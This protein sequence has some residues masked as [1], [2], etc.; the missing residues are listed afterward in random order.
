MILE[1]INVLVDPNLDFAC[2]LA[3]GVI[4]DASRASAESGARLWNTTLEKVASI[5][6]NCWCEE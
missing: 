3:T 5:F 6:K 2:Y 1:E 4:G